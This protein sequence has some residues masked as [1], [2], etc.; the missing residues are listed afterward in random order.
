MHFKG[1]AR[2]ITPDVMGDHPRLTVWTGDPH[3]EVQKG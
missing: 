3:A 1:P 2:T